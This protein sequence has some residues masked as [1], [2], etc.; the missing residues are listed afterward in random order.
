MTDPFV[1]LFTLC[2]LHIRFVRYSFTFAVSPQ[3]G[4]L[5]LVLPLCAAVPDTHYWRDQT[6][7][8]F[9]RRTDCSVAK[10]T[11]FPFAFAYGTLH[12]HNL[13]NMGFLE[14]SRSLRRKDS[15]V[16]LQRREQKD[17]TTTDTPKEATPRPST[18]RAPPMSIYNPQREDA[19]PRTAGRQ[20]LPTLSVDYPPNYRFPTPT[21]SPRT[22]SF[23]SRNLTVQNNVSGVNVGLARPVKPE[24]K[25]SH[26][27][28]MHVAQ[29]SIHQGTVKMSTNVLPSLD[30]APVASPKKEK[31]TL[32]KSK[33]STWRSFFQRRQSR[34][35]V[36][37]F[38]SA[39]PKQRMNGDSSVRPKEIP[40]VPRVPSPMATEHSRPQSRGVTRQNMRAEMDKIHF[41]KQTQSTSKPFPVPNGQWQPDRPQMARNVSVESWTARQHSGLQPH[42]SKSA[43][44]S[45]MREKPTKGPRL[46]VSIP[47]VELERYSVM[48]EKLLKP[49][50]SLMERRKTVVQGLSLPSEQSQ[51]AG[52]VR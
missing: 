32:H 51:A 23:H 13:Y 36:P 14:R 4:D 16:P 37:D 1:P 50:V 21:D 5:S 18:G 48:F 9:S 43:A 12:S 6:N 46:E 49:K 34:P 26:T 11:F 30:A 47:A 2:G 42:S 52:R 22:P 33:S 15:A 7:F 41:S 8:T 20:P 24:Y 45:P 27:T 38:E 40:D 25:R 17:V 35:P 44:A 31:R 19:R 28:P 29:A 3:L 39:E 10:H